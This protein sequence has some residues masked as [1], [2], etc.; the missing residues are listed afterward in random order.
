[1]PKPSTKPRECADQ[2]SLLD[3][4]ALSLLFVF[5]LSEVLGGAIRYYAAELGLAWVSYLPHL[6]LAMAIVPMFFVYLVSRGLTSTYLTVS[7][8]FGV[9]T[10][11][12]IFNLGNSSQVEFGLWVFVGFLYGIV[13]LPSIIRVWGRLTPYA[14][15]L[16]AVA[17]TGVII[18]FFHSWPWV[19]FEYQIGATW[20]EAS[21]LWWTGGIIF[22][23]LAGFSRASTEAA[24]QILV[25]ALFLRRGLSK[26]WWIPMWILSGTAIV[27]TTHKTAIGIFALF[28]LLEIFCRGAF[29]P[30]W[31]VLPILFL[32]CDILLPFSTL[33][34]RTGWLG[35]GGDGIWT[36]LISSSAERIE[37]GW[38]DWIAMIFTRGNLYLGRGLGGIGTAQIYF[39]PGRYSPADNVAVYLYG[40][41]GILGLGLLCLYAVRVTRARIDGPIGHFFFFCACFV[42][43]EGMTAN[44]VEGSFAAMAFGASLR[45]FG[46]RRTQSPWPMAAHARTP[47]LLGM[48]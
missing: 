4:V 12:G 46:E 7:V 28:S 37:A 14:A 29:R 6:A 8:L 33:F 44:V 3:R 39:E 27:L 17:V 5:L 18:N 38:P 35:S 19:G 13:V 43:L 15:L 40:S 41:F 31:R 32:C 36:L 21:R 22:E 42:L 24:I 20:I 26:V 34:V 45:Y 1:M 48:S 11:Y 10:V 9:G 23:R 25:L 47:A 2:L 16:W 30:L